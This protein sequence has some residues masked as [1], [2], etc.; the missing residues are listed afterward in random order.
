MSCGL[1]SSASWKRGVCS[2]LVKF[3]MVG[4]LQSKLTSTLCLC[5]LR[6]GPEPGEAL[7]VFEGPLLSKAKLLDQQLFQQVHCK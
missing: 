2:R 5:L 3:V 6:D 1:V 7:P 4:V